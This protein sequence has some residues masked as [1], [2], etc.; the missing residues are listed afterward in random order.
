MQRFLQREEESKDFDL[1]TGSMAR[2]MYGMAQV[3]SKH[4]CPA[5]KRLVERRWA[6]DSKPDS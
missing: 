3:A 2:Y 5:C 6:L 4:T 1:K